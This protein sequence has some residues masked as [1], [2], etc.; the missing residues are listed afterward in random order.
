M[1]SLSFQLMHLLIKKTQIGSSFYQVWSKQHARPQVGK[2]QLCIST[3]DFD[4]IK[5]I[6]IKS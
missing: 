3:I 5:N 4:I 2:V 1:H 6:N